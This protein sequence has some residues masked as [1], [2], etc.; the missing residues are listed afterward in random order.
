[1]YRWGEKNSFGAQVPPPGHPPPLC[2]LDGPGSLHGR[3]RRGLPR[4]AGGRGGA[5]P[6]ALALALRGRLGGLVHAAVR[7]AV[8]GGEG[9]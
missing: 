2:V 4:D 5:R 6:A 3:L 7:I 9:W 1:M 8:W